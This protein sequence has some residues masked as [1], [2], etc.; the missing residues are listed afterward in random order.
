MPD[1]NCVEHNSLFDG[2]VSKLIMKPI[3]I[4]TSNSQVIYNIH[5]HDLVGRDLATVC[6]S[7]K[8]N[9]DKCACDQINFN[10]FVA[11]DLNL[12]SIA[13]RS[14][15]HSASTPVVFLTPTRSEIDTGQLRKIYN[16]ADSLRSK[17]CY[18]QGITI[19]QILGPQSIEY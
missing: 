1:E 6:S 7:I 8:S 19:R 10:L 18:P 14:F 3:R 4:Q 9:I 13:G 15:S 17:A 2:R 12:P 5:N 11:G 16:M